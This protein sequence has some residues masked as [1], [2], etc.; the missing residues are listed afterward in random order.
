MVHPPNAPNEQQAERV[1]R[2]HV[3]SFSGTGLEGA[4]GFPSYQDIPQWFEYTVVD[5]LKRTRELQK[6][7]SVVRAQVQMAPRLRA[8]RTSLSVNLK[9]TRGHPRSLLRARLEQYG[10]MVV[11]KCRSN[12]VGALYSIVCHF[13]NWS[14]CK[15]DKTILGQFSRTATSQTWYITK[16]VSKNDG[17]QD[18][19]MGIGREQSSLVDVDNDLASLACTKAKQSSGF[20]VVLCLANVIVYAETYA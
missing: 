8:P 16:R 14:L 15:R 11:R 6:T 7:H 2:K 13:I 10:R 5:L 17:E 1:I 9:V 3:G 20:A 12:T 18:V 19:S 4:N